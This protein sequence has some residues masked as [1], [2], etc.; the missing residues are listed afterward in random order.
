MAERCRPPLSPRH[1]A[2]FP[3]SAG[4]SPLPLLLIIL[5]A[6]ALARRGV[7]GV[8][9]APA[10]GA[11]KVV[12]AATAR[13]AEIV[14]A[15]AHRKAALWLIVQDHDELRAIVG[16]AVQRLVGNDERGSRQCGRADAIEHILRDG[17]TVERSLGVVP[18]IDRDRRRPPSVSATAVNTCVPIGLS[19]LRIVTG[20]SKPTSKPRRT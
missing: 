5:L 11:E 19:G 12:P 18:A 14:L 3:R 20:T 9:I 17:D 10:K 15:L 13:D 16:L 8:R 6:A 7:L 2:A 4:S 1:A